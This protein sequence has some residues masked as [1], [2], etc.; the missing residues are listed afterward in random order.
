MT[1]AADARRAPELEPDPLVAQ[2]AHLFPPLD[3]TARRI[4]LAT[5][6]LLARQDRATPGEIATAAGVATGT[7]G[8]QI[9]I[10]PGVFRDGDGAVIGFWGLTGH[11]MPHRLT[12]SGGRARYTW[13][14][15]D[16]LFIPDLLGTTAQV[17]SST[18]LD[19]RPV[20][21]QVSPLGARPLDPGQPPLHVSFRL[22]AAAAWQEDVVTTFCHHVFFLF[23]DEVARWLADHPG[24]VALP[25]D[26][27]FR[28][29]RQKNAHQFGRRAP[30]AD[31]PSGF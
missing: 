15:W 31:P 21:L 16:A 7:V 27:A 20:G 17:D 14:A 4:A 25:L 26:D 12:L 9:E 3:R 24:T 29:G 5:Y 6:R 8:E 28:A 2:L 30:A 10:W 22:P 18:P 19:G 1:E 23:E 13:C 11:A